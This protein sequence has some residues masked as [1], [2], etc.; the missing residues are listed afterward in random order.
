MKGTKTR[1]MSFIT[2]I[3]FL[4][5]LCIIGFIV[6]YFLIYHK[7]N[8]NNT[9]KNNTTNITNPQIAM[10]IKTKN[11]DIPSKEITLLSSIS[12]TEDE[13]SNL[14]LLSLSSIPNINQHIEDLKV[15][16]EDDHIN[17]NANI[18]YKDLPLQ[19][20]FKFQGR[21]SHGKGILHYE[22]GKIGFFDIPQDIIMHNLKGNPYLKISEGSSDIIVDI[23]PSEYIEVIN[24]STEDSV[25]KV[26]LKG[27]M[28]Y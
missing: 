27:T 25:L 16:I 5:T 19:A 10:D 1:T 9:S 24:I 7:T 15:S 8:T 4:L 13:L 2:V 14:F 6:C 23:F 11:I 26:N 28:A 22:Q 3:N 17:L 12:L 18:T 20:S 21:T